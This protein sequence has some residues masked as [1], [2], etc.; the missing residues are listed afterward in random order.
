MLRNQQRGR[1]DGAEAFDALYRAHA[2]PLLLWLTRRTLDP[3]VAMELTAETFANAYRRR[4]QFRGGTEPEA[5]AWLY[6]IAA[7]EH[8][9]YLRRGR[10][11][12]RAL[13]RLGIGAPELD[14]DDLAR[15]VELAGLDH[16]RAEVAHQFDEL[17]EAQREAVRLRVVE[18]LPYPVVASRLGISEQTAR[19]RV[20]RGLRVLRGALTKG[21]EESVA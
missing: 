17:P 8:H 13:G 15:V 11:E 20:S 21:P 12:Q 2:Q 10:V 1:I 7:N 18:D 4:R 16:L 5:A 9:Q 14:D 19:A 3:H 6:R